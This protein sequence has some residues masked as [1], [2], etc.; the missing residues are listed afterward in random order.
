MITKK[1]HRVLCISFKFDSLRL[2]NVENKSRVRFIEGDL[3]ER[4]FSTETD[5]NLKNKFYLFWVL[6]CGYFLRRRKRET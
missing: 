2:T 5:W 1:L 6:L 3:L 4:L